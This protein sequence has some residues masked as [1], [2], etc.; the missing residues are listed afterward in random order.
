MSFGRVCW[1]SLL[2]FGA[3]QSCT[4]DFDKFEV[5]EPAAS[6]SSSGGSLSLAGTSA[7]TMSNVAGRRPGIAGNPSGTGAAGERAAGGAAPSDGG[8][9]GGGAGGGAGAAGAEPDPPC[10]G[11]CSL[12]HALSECVDDQC[13]IDECEPSWGDCNLAPSDGC[14][15]PLGADLA[16]CGACDRACSVANVAALECRDGACASSCAPGFANCSQVEMPDDGCETPVVADADNCGGCDNQCPAGFICAGG[17]CACDS[18]NDCGNGNGVECVGQACRC[19]LTLCRP[20]ERCRDVQ[21]DKLCSCNDGAAACLDNE[22]CCGAGGCTD[23]LSNASSCGACGQACSP[24]FVCAGGACECDSA[25]DCGET[26]EPA[27]GAA[28]AGGAMAGGEGGA[29]GAAPIAC[30]AGSCVCHGAACAAGQR[31]LPNGSCG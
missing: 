28:G 22:I 8:A 27:E 2:L 19:D 7:G 15:R 16:S 30:V 13:A 12:E 1:A 20:G 23:V 18:K 21:G 26:S 29:G 6:G 5:E 31:C 10:G 11:V 14:E 17:H 9:A 25:Q 4:N 3:A 24:G